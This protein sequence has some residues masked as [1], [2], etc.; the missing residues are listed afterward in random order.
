VPHANWE[1]LRLADMNGDGRA[2]YMT[3]GVRGSLAL[4]LNRGSLG[5][6]V[7]WLGQGGI[8]AG[9][10]VTEFDQLVFAD[11]SSC[12]DFLILETDEKID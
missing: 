4:W 3:V 5:A 7:K 6:D 12:V 8:T 11:V 2:D 10:S 9:G 1:T